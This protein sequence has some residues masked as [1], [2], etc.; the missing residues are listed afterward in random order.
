MD[1]K[2]KQTPEQLR[3]ALAGLGAEQIETPYRD[4]GWTV[5]QVVHELGVAADGANDSATA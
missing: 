4:G 3:A 5:R 1:V 2:L